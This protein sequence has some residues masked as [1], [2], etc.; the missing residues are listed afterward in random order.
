VHFF[1][2]KW[3]HDPEFKGW[4]RF[5][6]KQQGLYCEMCRSCDSA[7]A[8]GSRVWARD[9]YTSMRR[10]DI[11][12]HLKSPMHESTVLTRKQAASMANLTRARW[13]DYTSGIVQHFDNLFFLL[14]EEIA[15]TKFARFAEHMRNAGVDTR[16]VGAQGVLYTSSR[17]CYEAIASM[18]YVLRDRL[19]RTLASSPFVGVMADESTDVSIKKQLLTYVSHLDDQ[20]KPVVSF[21]NVD[22]IVDGSADTIMSSMTSTLEQFGL[23]WQR[24]MGFASDG[25]SVM[26]GSKNGVAAQI[27]RQNDAV[28][29]THCLA[30]KLALAAAQSCDNITYLKHTFKDALSSI[31]YYFNNSPVRYERLK[32]LQ[33]LTSDPLLR[34]RNPRDLRWLSH[35]NAVNS[36]IRVL[37]SLLHA[38]QTDATEYHEVNAIGLQKI[39]FSRE[40]VASLQLFSEVLPLVN[41]VSRVF[42]GR[43]LDPTAIDA[44]I[45]TT[46]ST[47][48]DMSSAQNTVAF[49]KRV[50]DLIRSCTDL[51][52]DIPAEYKKGRSGKI[53]YP[54]TRKQFIASMR[55]NIRS[56][57]PQRPILIALFDALCPSRFAGL[58]GD[59]LRAHGQKALEQIVVQFGRKQP[60]NVVEDAVNVEQHSDDPIEVKRDS[61]NEVDND[62]QLVDVEMERSLEAKIE[63]EPTA[64]GIV[65]YELELP[66]LLSEWPFWVAIVRSLAAKFCKDSTFEHQ[67]VQ[68]MRDDVVKVICPSFCALAHR[69]LILPLT[70]VECERGFSAMNRIKTIDRNRLLT[71]TLSRLMR[72]SLAARPYRDDREWVVRFLRDAARHWTETKIRRGRFP[73]TIFGSRTGTA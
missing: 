50:D 13:Q 8:N 61:D 23:S 48:D 6:E 37:P 33:Q 40:F 15:H 9:V 11:K 18:D 68:F 19:I 2:P 46:I 29:A 12:N 1:R 7:N 10:N 17:F 57:F 22:Q 27:M 49:E 26:T 63:I 20:G 65:Q 38:F 67:L 51:A 45:N 30:H 14:R 42:Q 31:F 59:Q 28:I 16:V 24:V 3:L 73:D 25:A 70:T 55:D 44:L 34:L 5:D 35:E 66:K 71:V 53:D 60:K 54:E 56:R 47:I 69:A 4:L 72:I 43:A 52:L 64:L 32:A 58:E 36:I 21:L 41:G 62:D 39:T